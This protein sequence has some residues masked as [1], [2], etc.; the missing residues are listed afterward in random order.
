MCTLWFIVNNSFIL[1]YE[2]PFIGRLL[3]PNLDRYLQ[4]CFNIYVIYIYIYFKWSI[5]LAS[6][7]LALSYLKIK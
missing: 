6:H 1:D 2:A 5:K 4:F 3:D 7:D